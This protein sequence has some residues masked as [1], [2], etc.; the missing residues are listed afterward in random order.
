MSIFDSGVAVLFSD[1]HLSVPARYRVGGF[2]DGV[3][4]RVIRA[5]PDDTATFSGRRFVVGTIFIDVRVSDAPELGPGD[6]LEIESALFVI[7]GDPQRDPDRLV[8]HAEARA[9]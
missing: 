7:T 5:M 6:T 1:P 2:G 3:A 8:W 9:L 4:L